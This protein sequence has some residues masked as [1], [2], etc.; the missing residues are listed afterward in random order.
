MKSSITFLFVISFL[1][2]AGQASAANPNNSSET[3]KT[4]H[5]DLIYA[6]EEDES[7][8]DDDEPECE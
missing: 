3:L 7:E 4:M 6:D 5:T 2:L 1:L 8:E